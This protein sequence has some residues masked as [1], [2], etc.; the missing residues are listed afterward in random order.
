VS[1]TEPKSRRRSGEEGVVL[2]M[3][4]LLV[5]MFSGLGLLAL[6]HVQGELRSSSAYMDSTQAAAAAETA[7]M[8]TATDMRRNWRIMNDP[9]K[10]PNYYDQFGLALQAGT[11]GNIKTGFSDIFNGASD[12]P[13]ESLGKLPVA[14]LSGTAP[15]ALT[16]TGDGAGPLAHGYA[17]VDV[18]QISPQRAPPP[19]GF[20]AD[21]ASRTYDWYYFTVTSRARYGYG[22][23]S[24]VVTTDTDGDTDTEGV[25][26][27]EGNAVMRAHMKIG[28]VDSL[29]SN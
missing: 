3:V 22:G 6:R 20:S 1:R 19:P 28:P 15:T 21:D 12:C 18:S 29:Q 27:M 7:I 16:L 4:I 26:S 13:T 23:G 14:S 25:S 10:C 17:D 11:T 8:M 2:L 5:V 9:D 24:L